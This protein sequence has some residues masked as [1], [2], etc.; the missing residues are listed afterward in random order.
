MTTSGF[1]FGAAM[2][3]GVIG[4]LVLGLISRKKPN[5]RVVFYAVFIV[6]EIASVVMRYAGQENSAFFFLHPYI[7]L[8]VTDISDYSNYVRGIRTGREAAFEKLLLWPLIV[9]PIMSAF[10]LTTGWL[11]KLYFR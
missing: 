11:I 8:L 10:V 1:N 5:L 7:A 9:I 3:E 4:C 2:A 6:L